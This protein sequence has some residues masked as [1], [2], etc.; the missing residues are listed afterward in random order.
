MIKLRFDC[1][2]WPI[3]PNYYREIK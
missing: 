1:D 2:N 3:L